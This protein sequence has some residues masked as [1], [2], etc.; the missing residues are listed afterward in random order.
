MRIKIMGCVNCLIRLALTSIFVCIFVACDPGYILPYS[1]SCPGFTG[2]CETSTNVLTYKLKSIDEEITDGRSP[3]G[4]WAIT[5]TYPI[6][7]P[8]DVP[9]AEAV[10]ASVRNLVDNFSCEGQ[11]EETFTSENVYLGAEIFSKIGRAHV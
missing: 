6:I 9:V 10:N 5:K 7:E 2:K 11:G 3:F 1:S 8:E 4:Y